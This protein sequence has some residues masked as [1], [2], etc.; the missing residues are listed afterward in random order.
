MTNLPC[1]MRFRIRREGFLS[2]GE[3]PSLRVCRQALQVSWDVGSKKRRQLRRNAEA[4]ARRPFGRGQLGCGGDAG[5]KPGGRNEA[6]VLHDRLGRFRRT[7]V[8]RMQI[9]DFSIQQ[10]HVHRCRK[11]GMVESA[12]QQ[13]QHKEPSHWLCKLTSHDIV[14]YTP[15]FLWC[16]LIYHINRL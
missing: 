5:M 3:P 15:S 11:I 7:S 4:A 12:N 13:I 10:S 8:R 16:Q 2:A 14:D 9:N 6:G 1:R